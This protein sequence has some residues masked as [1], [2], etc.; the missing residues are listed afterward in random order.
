MLLSGDELDHVKLRTSAHG[1][2]DQGVGHSSRGARTGLKRTEPFAR[3][4]NG[5]RPGVAFGVHCARGMGEH[6]TPDARGE[7]RPLPPESAERAG[8]GI[9]LVE[10]R[11]LSS[12]ERSTGLMAA[13]P[14]FARTSTLW[15]MPAWPELRFS[16]WY[17]CSRA[18]T[19]A[20]LPAA[21]IPSVLASFCR[22]RYFQCSTESNRPGFRL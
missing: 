13:P 21:A 17:S 12:G 5:E 7:L 19:S 3:G 9:P 10:A 22:S 14:S 2:R 6:A 20:R 11:Q 4:V 16:R 18:T 15:N 8:D 1:A